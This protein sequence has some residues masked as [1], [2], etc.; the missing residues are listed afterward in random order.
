MNRKSLSLI[1]ALIPLAGYQADSYGDAANGDDAISKKESTQDVRVRAAK[2]KHSPGNS[3]HPSMLPVPALPVPAATV[4]PKGDSAPPGGGD[5]AQILPPLTKDIVE[6]SRPVATGEIHVTKIRLQG[7]T[8]LTEQELK[9]LLEPYENRNIGSDELQQLRMDLS[10]LYFRKGYVNSG[11]VIPDQKVENGVIALQAIE[12]KLSTVEVTGNRWLSAAYIDR[13]LRI[14][15]AGPLNIADLRDNLRAF[16]QNPLV[17]DVHAELLPTQQ[18]G[19]SRLLVSVKERH[20]FQ[21]ALNV[22]NYRSASTGVEQAHLQGK[23]FNLTGLGDEASVNFGATQGIREYSVGYA[24]PIWPTQAQANFYQA[25]STINI[26]QPDFKALGIRYEVRLFGG[27]VR[28]PVF[29]RGNHTLSLQTG[30]DVKQVKSYLFDD[31]PTSFTT[32]F[33][34]GEARVSVVNGGGTWSIAKATQM[35]SITGGIKVGTGLFDATVNAT[36]PDAKF[37]ALTGQA[38]HF[39]RVGDT[40]GTLKSRLSAQ[41]SFD[42]LIA[43]EKFMLG[44]ASSV[45][46]YVENQASGDNG[47]NLSVEWH[48]PLR[49]PSMIP[50]AF[51]YEVYP[52]V[53]SGITWDNHLQTRGVPS[54]RLLS[55][56]L[57][58][59]ANIAKQADVRLE[60][61]HGFTYEQRDPV[62]Y[63]GF[64]MSF[65]YTYQ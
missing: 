56:G 38:M 17:S 65:A 63:A 16:E 2:K 5:Q 3:S 54:R 50:F 33:Q 26:V 48:L 11:V 1:F 61:G 42:D 19:E 62:A 58:F 9:S 55:T 52:F 41:Y 7:Q 51:K 28:V 13:S 22:D 44:G 25:Q 31:M 12:G 21:L 8:I 4:L 24:I 14:G 59:S 29:K 57:G 60:W 47:A 43:T 23:Y 49:K 36:E 27:A 46:G 32:G 20:P 15:A 53:D 37:T 18:F 40:W 35:L 39:Y 10:K 34:N 30:L 45:R 6:V 64:L